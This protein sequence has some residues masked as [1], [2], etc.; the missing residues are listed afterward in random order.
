[1]T[2]FCVFL[3][4]EGVINH[5]SIPFH[6]L[7][8]SSTAER[9][10]QLQASLQVRVTELMTSFESTKLKSFESHTLEGVDG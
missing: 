8:T 1:M 10:F 7:T 9:D 2:V 5:F 6:A 4:P 3:Q